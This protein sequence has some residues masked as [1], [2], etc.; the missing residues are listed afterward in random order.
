MTNGKPAPEG[1]LLAAPLLG[2][3][4]ERCLV[5]EDAEPGV[6]AGH[7]A[8]AMVAALK[9]VPAELQVDDLLELAQ[10]L[11]ETFIDT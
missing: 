10:L 4:P 6:A 8:G 1:Y 5:V 7:A 11:A 9:E 3:E 2:V